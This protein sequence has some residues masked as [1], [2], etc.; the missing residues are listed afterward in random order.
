MITV[1]R[2]HH[3]IIVDFYGDGVLV[4]FDPLDGPIK[5]VAQQA[6]IDRAAHHRLLEWGGAKLLKQM[7]RLFLEN[8][9]ERLDQIAQGF[10][11]NDPRL[12]EMGSQLGIVEKSGAW[13]SYKSDRIGQGKKNACDFLRDNPEMAQEIE[14]AIRAELLPNE[15]LAEREPIV[16]VADQP[17]EG[18][19]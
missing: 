2:E 10:E 14:A 8:A 18:S 5:P 6:I 15:P 17:A 12:V 4:F 9:D 16:V 19:F 13:Y 1:I 3:G 7:L 11:E